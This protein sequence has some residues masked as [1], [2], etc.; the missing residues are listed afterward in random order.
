MISI[1][2]IASLLG[3]GLAK[4]SK[5]IQV[6]MEE[7]KTNLNLSKEKTQRALQACVSLIRAGAPITK[8]PLFMAQLAFETGHFGSVVAL[9]DNNLSGIKFYGQKN[10]TRGIKAPANEGDYYAHFDNFDEW[11]K[12]YIRIL[13]FG[14]KPINATDSTDFVRRLAKNRY[15]DT[16]NNG[17]AKYLNGIKSLASSYTPI[18]LVAQN[19]T[20]IT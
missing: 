11:A 1:I 20:K 18:V 19:V 12:D 14:S 7:I 9:K 10:A 4:G 13:S 8:L 16:A 5:K 2:I 3:I 15:F 17:E 6:K